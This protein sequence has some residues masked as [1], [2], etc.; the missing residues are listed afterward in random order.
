MAGWGASGQARP[1]QRHNFGSRQSDRIPAVVSKG[2][3][4]TRAQPCREP[5]QPQAGEGEIQVAIESWLAHKRRYDALS[6][7]TLATLVNAYYAAFMSAASGTFEAPIDNHLG[8]ISAALS[9][10][11]T[12]VDRDSVNWPG[13]G[14]FGGMTKAL[15][16]RPSSCA[17]QQP[18]LPRNVAV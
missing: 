13:P 16:Q 7:G 2:V 12:Q 1:K 10:P 11:N 4:F 5:P 17:V 14:E 9:A 3:W 8:K 6:H 18:S 15:A